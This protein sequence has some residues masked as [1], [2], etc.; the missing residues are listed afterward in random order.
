M[1][2]EKERARRLNK[3]N[4]LMSRRG[5]DAVYVPGNST[6]G[7]NAYGDYRYLTDNRIIYYLV[8]VVMPKGGEPIGVAANNMSKVMLTENTFVH[9]VVIDLDQLGAV[10]SILRDV[11]RGKS[12]VG[13]LLEVLPTAWIQRIHEELPDIEF[14]DIT[15]D[16][17][18]IRMDKSEEEVAAQIECGKI[19]DAGYKAVCEMLR[20]GV[21]E[22]EVLAAMDKAMQQL[23][24][25]ESFSL[26]TSGSFNA[27]HGGLP[28]LHNISAQNRRLEY[29]DVVGMEI[30]PRYYGYWA[31]LV[32]TVCVGERNDDVDT[33]RRVGS[34]AIAK[35]TEVMK[36]GVPIS[37]L[38]DVMKEHIESAG[39]RISLP[40]GHI[41]AIDLNEERIA[42][43]NDRPLL[44]GMVVILHPTVLNNDMET[45][46][47]WG[48]SYL[49]THDGC[50]P[51]CKSTSDLVVANT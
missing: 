15:N 10:I 26:I 49:V 48:E 30:T 25:E 2:S 32:R 12:T 5:M 21:Y 46:I 8:S 27:K 22:N 6:V 19:A 44:E 29:G 4:E 24:S 7:T 31:Q 35:A 9:D 40:C 37:K 33:F 20:P 14:V 11:C 50:E 23:G 41:C 3:M 43:G 36:P 18:L 51:I 1:F 34:E 38:Y 13:T 45:G 17:F 16:M 47:Y 39:L 28:P 42:P